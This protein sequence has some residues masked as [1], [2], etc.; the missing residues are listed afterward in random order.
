MGDLR[1]PNLNHSKLSRSSPLLA[2]HPSS[3]LSLLAIV[4]TELSRSAPI[5][6]HVRTYQLPEI[7]PDLRECHR[8]PGQGRGPV[9]RFIGRYL[10]F[11]Q[12]L[13]EIW[14]H[15]CA[16]GSSVFGRVRRGIRGTTVSCWRGMRRPSSN[17]RQAR[18]NPAGR[19]ASVA[20]DSIPALSCS[21]VTDRSWGFA[22]MALS[23][24]TNRS[25]FL[26]FVIK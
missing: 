17:N 16:E 5:R 26:A 10:P 23:P 20:P 3:P 1:R 12:Q 7:L 14:C 21:V 2:E 9:P 18:M 8:H 13:L 25:G 6:K 19:D 11:V 15:G 4:K 24:P 22:G